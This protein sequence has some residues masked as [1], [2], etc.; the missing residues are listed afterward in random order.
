MRGERANNEKEMEEEY[1]IEDG[2]DRGKENR[3]RV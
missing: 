3:R 1:G 2:N